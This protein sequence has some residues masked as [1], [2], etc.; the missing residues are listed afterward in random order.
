MRWLDN[1]RFDK[2]HSAV[3]L[4]LFRVTAIWPE[5]KELWITSCNDKTHMDGSKHYE[6]KAVDLRSHDFENPELTTGYIVKALGPQYTVL[7]E[8]PKTPNAHIHIQFNG[9]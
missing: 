8:D 2:L 1:C 4:A 6:G 7:Y 5:D 3:V 9:E